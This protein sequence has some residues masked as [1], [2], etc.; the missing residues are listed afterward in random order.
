MYNYRMGIFTDQDILADVYNFCHGQHNADEILEHVQNTLDKLFALHE[1]SFFDAPKNLDNEVWNRILNE[2]HNCMKKNK[3]EFPD[4][5]V[6][7]P[8]YC[9]SKKN[10]VNFISDGKGITSI[11]PSFFGISYIKFHAKDM[12]E[13]LIGNK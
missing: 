5:P 8:K 6:I 10:K 9:R 11:M 2:Y 1:Y 12:I 4:R 3:I 7:G 13:E